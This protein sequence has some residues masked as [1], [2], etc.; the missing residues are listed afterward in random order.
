MKKMIIGGLLAANALL[1]TSCLEGGQNSGSDWDYGVV[2][3]TTAT[4]FRRIVTGYKWGPLYSRSIESDYSI[5]DGDCIFINFSYNMNSAEN[6][7]AAANGYLTVDDNPVYGVIQQGLVN[8][9]SLTDTT[10]LLANE[11]TTYFDI[12][13]YN[14]YVKD[15]LFMTPLFKSSLTDQK[16]SYNISFNPSQ[17]VE[18]ID[19]KR[20]YNLY[21]RV[22]KLED[23]K[24]PALVD[25]GQTIALNLSAVMAQM[26]N[27]EKALNN[28][29]MY[30]KI[31]YVAELNADSTAVKSW[32][33]TKVQ[34]IQIPAE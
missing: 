34:S 9:Y 22:E 21:F 32:G 2:E 25:N 1:L 29:L 3:A 27:V 8:S 4:S 33:T 19:G 7:N 5:N 17:P 6:Q 30:F 18:E 10:R 23:G 15:R 11:I 12:E 14:A 20:V 26:R 28:N 16:N 31:N 13:N 24:A